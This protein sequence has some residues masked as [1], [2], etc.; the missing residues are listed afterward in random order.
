ML[1]KL[2]ELWEKLDPKI[3]IPA[4]QQRG[5]VAVDPAEADQS[6]GVAIAAVEES[7]VA[8]W[9]VIAEIARRLAIEGAAAFFG[10]L[11]RQVGGFLVGRV[12]VNREMER[13][14]GGEIAR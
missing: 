13:Q 12:I 9:R 1:P 10:Q 4:H 2:F 5:E 8:P 3:V 7:Q 11:A 14:H 6:A